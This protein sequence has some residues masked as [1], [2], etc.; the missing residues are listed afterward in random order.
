MRR[1]IGETC[2]FKGLV[3]EMGCLRLAV[4]TVRIKLIGWRRTELVFIR[5]DGIE[6]S[7]LAI[8]FVLDDD[9]V[10]D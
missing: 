2:H 4:S 7:T 9:M 3:D 6:G 10:D 1:I 8:N 5:S